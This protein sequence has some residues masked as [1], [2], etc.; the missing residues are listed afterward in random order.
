M[1][2]RIR[3]SLAALSAVSVA[4]VGLVAP[5]SAAVSTIVSHDVTA[6]ASDDTAG[7]ALEG[8]GATATI[9]EDA[10]D[11]L[12]TGDGDLTVTPST[13][14][15]TYLT[16]AATG[17]PL[18]LASLG[19]FSARVKTSGVAPS[20]RFTLS[21]SSSSTPSSTSASGVTLTGPGI[22]SA[23][24]ASP[25]SWTSLDAQGDDGPFGAVSAAGDQH[26]MYVAD[27]Y[28]A[29][30][31]TVSSDA[32]TDPAAAA[33]V[34]APGTQHSYADWAKRCTG[35]IASY[36]LGWDASASASAKP[37]SVDLLG[38]D[39]STLVDF[40]TNQAAGAGAQGLDRLSGADRIG[41]AIAMS[42]AVWDDASADAVVLATTNG[43]A[44]GLGGGTL[45]AD[46]GGPLLLN[47]PT[48]LNT[49]VRDEL[50]RV[51]ANGATIYLAGGTSALNGSVEKS[52]QG[53]ASNGAL[54]GKGITVKRLPGANRYATARVIANEV[55]KVTGQTDPRTIFVAT[56]TNFPDALSA[57]A[58]AANNGG[59]VVLSSKNSAGAGVIP[60]ET[61]AFLDAHTDAATFGIGGSAAQALGYDKNDPFAFVGTDRYETSTKVGDAFFDY[62][63]CNTGAIVVASGESAADAL[64]G[65]AAAGTLGFPVILV[66]NK[67]Y[68]SA[69]VL[70]PS[71]TAFL[72]ERAQHVF[73]GI[74][75][76]GTGAVSTTVE[77]SLNSVIASK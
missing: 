44:D 43:F 75:G 23:D 12:I 3:H 37:A 9:N 24:D 41:T 49:D 4:T 31:G 1:S 55:L 21:C 16:H 46:A 45:A 68:S 60:T 63:G 61:A 20:F 29:A 53:L 65:G 7:W 56:G 58:A 17:D 47:P 10:A 26:P 40:G 19:G 22:S 71:T 13:T 39:Y 34:W 25:A 66:P 54:K 32:P 57:S 30:D 67:R 36:A 74:L 42:D 52:L 18:T 38:W 51:L 76:G 64:S 50:V 15:A 33:A 6:T 62:L 28:V 72:T 73:G 48:A 2:R 14:T 59:V 77:N 70:A 27:K 8:T 11:E 35:P 5:A 69:S